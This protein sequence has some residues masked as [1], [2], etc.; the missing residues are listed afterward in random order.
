VH[1]ELYY[2]C[3]GYC[4][5]QPWFRACDSNLERNIAR[6]G[7]LAFVGQGLAVASILSQGARPMNKQEIAENREEYYRELRYWQAHIEEWT[8][9]L[10]RAQSSDV[11][12]TLWHQEKRESNG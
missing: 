9:N 7:V 8:R 10:K 12:V 6:V 11:D 5:C 1:W 2:G 4:H 3:A